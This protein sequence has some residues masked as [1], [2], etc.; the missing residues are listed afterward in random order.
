MNSAYKK[1]VEFGS[2]LSERLWLMQ[3]DL[4]F[5]DRRERLEDWFCNRVLP[6][7][8]FLR[9]A[10]KASGILGGLYGF[11]YALALYT[12]S[13]AHDPRTDYAFSLTAKAPHHIY[14]DTHHSN[15]KEVLAAIDSE[16]RS[17]YPHLFTDSRIDMKLENIIEAI[18]Q[19]T[20]KQNEDIHGYGFLVPDFD[21]DGQI[22][23]EPHIIHPITQSL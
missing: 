9:K 10:A 14:I 8:G 22:G 20:E 16:W 19:Y 21:A 15:P 17:T 12:P 18:G 23:K 11:V 4:L 3:N 7:P 1:F 13:F 2:N 5:G 6:R